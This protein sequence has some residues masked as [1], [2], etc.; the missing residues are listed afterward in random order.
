MTRQHKSYMLEELGLLCYN[1]RK[2]EDFGRV[3]QDAVEEAEAFL[4]GPPWEQ[5]ERDMERHMVLLI[6]Y[7]LRLDDRSDGFEAVISQIIIEMGWDFPAA[8]CN[9]APIQAVEPTSIPSNWP[10]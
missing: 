4:D 5:C 6:G 10:F 7:A 1:F 8:F 3:A 9:V 2:R